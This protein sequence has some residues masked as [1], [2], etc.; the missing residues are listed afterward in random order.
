MTMTMDNL[1]SSMGD[2]MTGT[3]VTSERE[4]EEEPSSMDKMVSA[5]P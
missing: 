1:E 2:L 3:A 5:A 4:E